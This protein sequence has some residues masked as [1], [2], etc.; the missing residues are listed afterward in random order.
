MSTTVSYKGSV[1]ATISNTVK[2]LLT[3]GKYLEDDITIT[4]SGGGGSANL[5]TLHLNITP[6]TSSQSWTETPAQ[7]YD[8]FDEVEVSV[9]AMPAGS[10]TAPA[11]ITGTNADKFLGSGRLALQ[12]VVDVTPVVTDAGYISSG[13]QGQSTV[14]LASDITV[15]NARTFHPSTSDQTV[16]TNEYINGT[17]T[18]KAVQLTNLLAENIKSGV[19]VKVGD[20]TDD[21]CVT[22]VTGTYSGG[23]VQFKSGTYTV[24]ETYNSAG[25]RAIT[26]IAEIGFTPKIFIMIVSDKSVVSGK[27]YAVIHSSFYNETSNPW[28]TTVRY[29][30]TSNTTSGHAVASSWTTQSNYY[31][32]LSNGTIYYRTYSTFI[33][34]QNVEYKWFA[35]G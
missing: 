4:D 27:Q 14:L 20:D 21:D 17:Q 8:G 1:I 18:I 10:V 7:G 33:L 22:A 31:L 9:D 35:I 29:S 19:T 13:T 6:S 25:N 12:K 26:T 23:S 2:K 3:K 24:P 32:Y 16:D 5:E 34:F 15:R 28:R 30:N 11:T